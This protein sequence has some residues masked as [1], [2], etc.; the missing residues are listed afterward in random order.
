MEEKTLTMIEWIATSIAI[1]GYISFFLMNLPI[2]MTYLYL[3][4]TPIYVALFVWITL[5]NKH[6]GL[7][8]FFI[9]NLIFYIREILINV[10]WN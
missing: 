8:T 3:Y 9:I 4:L 6:Y 2:W 1:I 10:I 7:M 5:K